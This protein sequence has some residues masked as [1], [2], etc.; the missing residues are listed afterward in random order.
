MDAAAALERGVAA[1]Y[2]GGTV[3]GRDEVLA[4][5]GRMESSGRSAI[6]A[7]VLCAAMGLLAGNDALRAQQDVQ[8][9]EA[10]AMEA[11]RKG[12]HAAARAGFEAAIASNTLPDRRLFYNLGNCHYRLGD[13]A[14]ARWAWEC[15]RLGMPRDPELL[16]NLALVEKQ[17]PPQQDGAEPFLAAVA[18]LRDS[19]TGSELLALC[20][21]C[22]LVAALGLVVFWRRPALRAAGAIALLPALGLTAELLVFG[23][24]RPPRAIVT[25]QAA[26]RAEPREAKELPVLATLAPGAAVEWLGTSGDWARVK[27][28]GRSG[29]VPAA[30]VE[31]VR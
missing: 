29:Y 7:L 31:A 10:A 15:A 9:P 3:L 28:A 4:I 20:V 11:W 6:G 5:V 2:G 19:L 1:R 13:L 25:A 16:A 21:L 14:R 24:Q 23:P 8:S 26:M 30:A 17:L 12:D 27:A 22:N 18:G